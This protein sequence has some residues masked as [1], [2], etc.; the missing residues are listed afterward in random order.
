[1]KRTYLT[2]IVIFLLLALI[3]FSCSDYRRGKRNDTTLMMDDEDIGGTVQI[4]RQSSAANNQTIQGMVQTGRS[5]VVGAK[6]RIQ[7]AKRYVMTDEQGRF[8]LPTG[9]YLYNPVP[10]TVGKEGWF[11]TGAFVPQGTT[12]VLFNT[13]RIPMQDDANYKFIPPEPNQ[14]EL[15]IDRMYQMMRGRTGGNMMG[16]MGRRGGGMMG[17]GM[18]GRGMLRMQGMEN[19][20]NCPKTIY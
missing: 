6:V 1:M 7:G 18:M 13:K 12:G 8:E 5:P 11:N 17:Q 20:C 10:V 19:I 9:D 14:M 2:T 4:S 15:M 3:G 16:M